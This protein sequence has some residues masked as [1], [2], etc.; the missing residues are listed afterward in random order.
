MLCLKTLHIS[1]YAFSF[2]WCQFATIINV[3]FFQFFVGNCFVSLLAHSLLTRTFFFSKSGPLSSKSIC[4][5]GLFTY[6][7]RLL[8]SF[9]CHGNSAPCHPAR[10][11][12]HPWKSRIRGFSHVGLERHMAPVRHRLCPL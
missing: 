1:L 8:A 10:Q 7:C 2:T 9:C 6:N 4:L 5:F 3:V 12:C 11:P